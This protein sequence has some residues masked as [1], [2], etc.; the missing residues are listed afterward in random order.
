MRLCQDGFASLSLNHQHKH[1]TEGSLGAVKV[2]RQYPWQHRTGKS[3]P[4]ETRTGRAR[5]PHANQIIVIGYP[6]FCL[7][8]GPTA[9]PNKEPAALR[10][11]G[12]HERREGRG[13]T[14][15]KRG[16]I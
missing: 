1:H 9:V 10:T 15:Y 4:P 6:E 2:L 8:S 13:A 7:S 12:V 5:W 14:L 16:T 3:K 11:A